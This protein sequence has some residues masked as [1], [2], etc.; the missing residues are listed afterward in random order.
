MLSVSHGKRLHRRL[1]NAEI[2]RA[3]PERLTSMK[4]L[5]AVLICNVLFVC[6]GCED[7]K[8]Y[9]VTDHAGN[10]QSGMTVIDGGWG[11][12]K[13]QDGDGRKMVVRG[14]YSY[15]EE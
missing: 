4:K 3:R 9:T 12:T 1:L 8:K 11:W 5:Y 13:F 10:V 2:Q 14:N 15:I 7:P 6:S